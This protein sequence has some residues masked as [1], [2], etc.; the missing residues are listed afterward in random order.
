MAEGKMRPLIAA[1]DAQV[2]K[3][4][5]N[6]AAQLVTRADLHNALNALSARIALD[7]V[8]LKQRADAVDMQLHRIQQMLNHFEQR[9]AALEHGGHH[10]N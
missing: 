3:D 2:R 6:L 1:G 9:I 10:V 4:M 7:V 5:A 8:H